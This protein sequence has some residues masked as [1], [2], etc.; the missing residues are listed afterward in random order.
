MTSF[1]KVFL[2]S[3]AVASVAIKRRRD[4]P[5]IHM[6]HARIYPVMTV[7]AASL[8]ISTK[9]L[10]GAVIAKL[11]IFYWSVILRLLFDLNM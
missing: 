1:A 3:L 9:F 2:A 11:L 4:A 10:G 5:V 6:I 7:M 8:H